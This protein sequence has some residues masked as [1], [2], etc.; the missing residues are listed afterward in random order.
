MKNLNSFKAVARA[1]E[2]EAARQA[3][4]LDNGGVIKQETRRWDDLK[5]ENYPLR[6]KEGVF[7]PIIKDPFLINNIP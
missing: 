2:Y 7:A 1:I 3:Q 5:G 4:I 6:S